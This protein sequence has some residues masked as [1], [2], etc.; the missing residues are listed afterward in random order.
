MGT[1]AQL[2]QNRSRVRRDELLAAAIELFA[3]GGSRAITHRAVAA[4]ADL[5]PASTTYY[6]ETIDDLIREALGAHVD[7]WTADLTNL[8][9]VEFEADVS[10][11]D[12]AAFVTAVFAARG[13]EVAALELSIFLAAA[14]EPE[15]QDN[16]AQAMQ[17]L[18][19]LA[20]SML[21]RVGVTDGSRLAATIVALIAGTA[22]RRQ[23]G[24]YSEQHEALLLTSAIRDL[25]AAQVLGPETV[26][27][28]LTDLRKA[29][30]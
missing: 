18:E 20:T 23:S 27:R 22:L 11:D 12:A 13:P 5:P 16:A 8:T 3:E 25:V 4:R 24:Q 10:I 2:T 17:A 15:L 1:R 30:A 19:S 6:F 21:K 28:T 14:R 29:K 26:D 9:Q 7:Q